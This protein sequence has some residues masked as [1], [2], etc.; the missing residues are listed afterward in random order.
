MTNPA[1]PTTSP[2]QW[3]PG[4][5]N[6]GAYNRLLAILFKPAQPANGLNTPGA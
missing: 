6:P 5:S 1:T 2:V 4:P 3:T